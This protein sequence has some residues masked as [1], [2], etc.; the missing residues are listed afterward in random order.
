MARPLHYERFYGEIEAA[1][2]ELR[3]G[4]PTGL[5][6]NEWGLDLPEAQQYLD[7]RR[8]LR[9]AADERLRAPRRLWSR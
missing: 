4:P 1:L 5:A 3:P 8:A 6:I 9:G 7:P 2:R